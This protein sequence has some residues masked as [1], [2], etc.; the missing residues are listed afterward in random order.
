MLLLPPRSK[1]LASLACCA[2]GCLNRPCLPQH[3]VVSTSQG[4][5]GRHHTDSFDPGV[6]VRQVVERG[7]GCRRGR[8]HSLDTWIKQHNKPAAATAAEAG[9]R[10]L[11]AELRSVTEERDILKKAAAYFASAS[12]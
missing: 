10:R 1:I 2:G 8:K 11:Q 7:H 4:N 5:G 9:I 3:P 6:Q 12:R